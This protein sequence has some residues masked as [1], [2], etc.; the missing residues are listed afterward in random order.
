MGHTVSA[1]LRAG[2]QHCRPC[3]VFI[4]VTS[5]LTMTEGLDILSTYTGKVSAKVPACILEG[6]IPSQE[7]NL[8]VYSQ[9]MFYHAVKNTQ[10]IKA[11][12]GKIKQ[13]HVKN[14]TRSYL[15]PFT[16]H[17]LKMD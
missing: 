16:K 5:S 2:Y 11:D 10:R 13:S 1:G 6:L 8:Y 17:K 9:L 15:T 3:G 14:E 4:P 12:A 7:I